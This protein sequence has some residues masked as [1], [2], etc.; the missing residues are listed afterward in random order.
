VSTVKATASEIWL[1]V[2]RMLVAPFG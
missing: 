1:P 2:G